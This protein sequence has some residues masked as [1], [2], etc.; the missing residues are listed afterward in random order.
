MTIKRV[1]A[2]ALLA[3]ACAQ[4]APT[5]DAQVQPVSGSL[6][7][8]EPARQWRLPD[9]LREI[10]GLAVSPDGRLFGHDDERAVIYEI[11]AREGALVKAFAL[12]DVQ[13][14]DFEGL[15]ITPS[16]DF[17]LTTS[18]G[19][20]HR[21]R[22]GAD[23]ARVAIETFDAGLRNVCEIEGL[24]YLAAEESLI[25]ACKRNEAR[26]M[27]DTVSLY[28]WRGGDNIARPWRQLPESELTNAAGVEH[29]R[30]SSLDIDPRS[31]RLI[32]LSARD[33]ALAEL[34]ADGVLSARALG[35]QHTQAEGAAVLADGSLAIADEAV[36]GRALLSIYEGVRQ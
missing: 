31:G 2:A 14:G 19:Q 6:F 36:D 18:Q 8:A 29:F 11:D 12:G 3:C 26:G 30:P 20:L 33:G 1:I 28:A 23:G 9:Q 34:S 35:P 13:R 10:S 21:F 15:A 5:A 7:A 17:W 27:R 22:E 32:L 25:L 24:A 16:G 4:P